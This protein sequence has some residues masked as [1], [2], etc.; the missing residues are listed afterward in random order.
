MFLFCFTTTQG[1]DT[2]PSNTHDEIA[3]QNVTLN[4]AQFFNMRN[5]I[6][7]EILHNIL[8]IVNIVQNSICFF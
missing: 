7:E 6:R 5:Q 4:T 3:L 2:F 8:C 1:V